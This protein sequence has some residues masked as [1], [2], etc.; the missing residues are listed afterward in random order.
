MSISSK[1]YLCQVVCVK[2][3]RH[4]LGTP[5]RAKVS[6]SFASIKE[7]VREVT[8]QTMRLATGSGR[9]ASNVLK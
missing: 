9:L 4:A 6:V 2:R 8:L 5:E 1:N 7:R 3:N